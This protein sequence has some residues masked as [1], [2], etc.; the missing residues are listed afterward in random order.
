MTAVAR[1][2]LRGCELFIARWGL[3]STELRLDLR[4][5]SSIEQLREFHDAMVPRLPEII[6]YLNQYPAGAIPDAD[7]PLAWTAL[8]L[9][10]VDNAVNK[11]RTPVL[12]TGIDIQRMVPKRGF[13]DQVRA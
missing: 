4:L 5:A 9:C 10:E 7:L 11:W 6:E 8:A 12:D 1:P 3:P 2:D 13:Y